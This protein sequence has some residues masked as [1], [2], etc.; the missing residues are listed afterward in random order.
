MKKTTCKNLRGACD[1][2][3]QGATAEEMGE[4]SKKHVMEMVNSGDEAHKAA[5]ESMMQLSQEDQHKWY[6]D[7][8]QGFNALP[9]A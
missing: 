7:F 2:E 1:A 4:N 5:M 6:E 9:E 8:K 3:I